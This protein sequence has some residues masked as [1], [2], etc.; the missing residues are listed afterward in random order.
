MNINDLK[1]TCPNLK[2]A[3]EHYRIYDDFVPDLIHRD[4]LTV[5]HPNEYNGQSVIRL[6]CSQ[7][8]IITEFRAFSDEEL[9][10]ID[11]LQRRYTDEWIRFLCTEKLPVKEVDVCSTVNQKVFDAL[12]NQESIESLRIK[13]LKCKEINDI[14]K[15]KNLKKLYLERASSLTDIS[16]I[17]LLEHLEVLILG[18]TTKIHDYSALKELKKLKVLGICSARTSY[19][20]VIKAIDINFI[21]EMPSLEYVDLSDVRLVK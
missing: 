2:F 16:P 5:Y 1:K 4:D 17:S 11:R 7:H 3:E 12:C 18:E 6:V 10:E 15:L 14:S 13:Y 19:N 20:T 9:K 21:E 8:P